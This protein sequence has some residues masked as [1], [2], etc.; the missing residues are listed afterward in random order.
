MRANLELA[1]QRKNGTKC[2]RYPQ[3]GIKMSVRQRVHRG[4]AEK[5]NLLLEQGFS[6]PTNGKVVL[7]SFSPQ[8]F[9]SL[10]KLPTEVPAVM[11][12]STAQVSIP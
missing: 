3:N 8:S 11:M 4:R 7:F 6:S 5:S 10:Q 9:P 1:Y 12:I 2:L